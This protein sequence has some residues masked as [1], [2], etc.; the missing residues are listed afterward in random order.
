M[1]VKIGINGFGRI[2]R[3]IM[4]AAQRMGADLDFV[5]VNDLT[6]APTLAHLLKYDSVHGLFPGEV[7]VK[8]SA[9]LVNGK[10][11]KVMA[12]KDP[13]QLPWKDL[14]VEVVMECTG[15]FREK[16]KAAKHLEAG[17][18]KVIISA[19][20]KEPDI[21]IVM[22]VNH[23][24]YDQ[25]KHHIISNASCT[26]NCL[27]PVAKV[28]LENF[29]IQ[30]GLMTTIHAYTNDQMILDFPHKDLRRA[31]AAALSMIPTTTGA[32]AAVSLVL[33][34]LKG[35]LDGMAI[36]V[37][38]PN[39]SLVDLVVEVEK[40]TSVEGVNAALKKASVGELKGILGYAEEPLVSVDFNGN[41][42]S[43]IVD[44]L[45]TTVLEER[46]I[47]VLSWYDNEMGYSARMV[48]LAR[49]ISS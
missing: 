6:D 45:S 15:L 48:D 13:A 39:V 44:A 25:N 20:A 1:G 18:K 7:Q 11:I 40:E 23:Q 41:E 27:A 14:G 34:Q 28:L 9:I 2:G 5:A 47:K 42:L 24:E 30:R 46:M 10:E 49:F 8:D 21:T 19:P 35:K 22:G 29:G 12:V 16:A 43:S 26:T 4:R 33:P 17:A 3:I 37:P 38:T 32:A 36:R 31:R